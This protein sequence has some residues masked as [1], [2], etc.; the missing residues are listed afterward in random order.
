ML[1]DK[2]YTRKI[3]RTTPRWISGH[4]ANYAQSH[5]EISFNDDD[6]KKDE[7]L[8]RTLSYKQARNHHASI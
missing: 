2:Y 5:H 3:T 1:A 4:L 8:A 7:Y 6:E